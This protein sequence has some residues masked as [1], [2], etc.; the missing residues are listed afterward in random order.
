MM[1]CGGTEDKLKN[2]VQ[3]NVNVCKAV[4]MYMHTHTRTY[5]IQ[6]LWRDP[7]SRDL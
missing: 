1:E 6:A 2:R 4:Y 3:Y 5:L 7:F